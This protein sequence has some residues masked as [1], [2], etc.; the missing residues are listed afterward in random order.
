[1]KLK[2]RFY[3][4]FVLVVLITNFIHEGGHW[5][6]GA[7]LGLDMQFGL[8]AVRYLSP[9]SDL[10]RAL[11]NAAGPLLTILQGIIAYVLV[12]RTASSRSP[13][14]MRQPSCGWRRAW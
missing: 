9:P 2:A 8:N 12:R 14:C 11:A 13:S 5:L 6:M 10:H 3:L 4:W 1:M 7:S